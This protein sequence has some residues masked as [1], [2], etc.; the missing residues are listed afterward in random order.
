M[1]WINVLVCTLAAVAAGSAVFVF[2]QLRGN[3]GF[4]LPP[5]GKVPE[6]RLTNQD[7]KRVEAKALDS[8]VTVFNF[9]FTSCPSVCPLLTQRMREL[10][11]RTR[12]LSNVQLVSI[13]VDPARDSPAV[14]KAYGTKHRA[15]FTRWTFL[16]GA[17]SDIEALV[18]K[19]FMSAMSPRA[20]DMMD[21]THGEHFV[22][23]DGTR[24]IRA[25]RR[26]STP[27]E[28]T[29]LER[30]VTQLARESERVAALWR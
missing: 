27:D 25:F 28:L 13:S 10:Q 24:S 18:V 1:R 16:T 7:G 5:I 8:R 9:I 21:I 19:G 4:H 11:E 14:L 3:A 2:A 6:F 30:I 12:G 23:V 29:E 15:D 20:G 17:F 26:V 22:V